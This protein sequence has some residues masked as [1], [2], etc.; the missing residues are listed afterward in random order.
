MED[1]LKY[2]SNQVLT[3]SDLHSTCYLQ[4]LSTRNTI[5][6][7]FL[8]NL[9][10]VINGIYLPIK[11]RFVMAVQPSSDWCSYYLSSVKIDKQQIG[12][13]QVSS[14][15]HWGHDKMAKIL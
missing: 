5:C 13:F 10:I 3:V 6:I 8:L 4:S 7:F 1:L 11:S 12:V 2:L 15:T 9:E 14:L